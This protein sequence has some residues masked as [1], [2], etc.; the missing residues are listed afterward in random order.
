MQHAQQC[1]TYACVFQVLEERHLGGQQEEQR[2]ARRTRARRA[3]NAVYVLTRIVRWIVLR[4]NEDQTSART[5]AQHARTRD[6]CT[7]QS[8][9]GTSRPRAATSVQ[10]STPLA[11][12]TNS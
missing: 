2:A 1:G 6:T 11:A 3:P 4:N 5:H 12:L 8:T 7:I 10:M 9:L